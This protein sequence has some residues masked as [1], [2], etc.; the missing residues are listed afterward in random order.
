M[1]KLAAVVTAALTL[2]VWPTAASAHE[3]TCGFG[4]ETGDDVNCIGE[5][6][7]SP[8]G[9]PIGQP[10]RDPNAPAY[11]YRYVPTCSGNRFEGG[12]DVMCNAAAMTCEARGEQGTAFWGWRRQVR[13]TLGD[14]VRIDGV[15]CLG[16]EEPGV[17]TTAQAADY[18]Q[19]EFQSLVIVRGTTRID[20][21]ARGLI[22]TD[23]IFSTD[24]VGPEPL[25]AVSILGHQVVITVTPEEYRWQFGDGGSLTTTVP[26][27]PLKKDV[28]HVY[29]KAGAYGAS[30]T[31]SWSGTFTIDG[32]EPI[33]IRG[34]ATT[35]GPE[36]PIRIL[37][38]QSELVDR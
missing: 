5:H 19:R 33:T 35:T 3:P 7:H 23:T 14:W 1:R 36:T 21:G 8:N 32:G 25:P 2:L 28:T 12:A 17:P 22:N 16:G 6:S 27:R 31:I 30:V 13:P 26:G 18:V 4:S 11:Q 9:D 34:R 15:V 20:P 37:T 10:A 24:K 38:A 29:T